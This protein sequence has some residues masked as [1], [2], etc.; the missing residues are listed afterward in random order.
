MVQIAILLHDLGPSA[1]V[2]NSEGALDQRVVVRSVA[3]FL[4]ER[5]AVELSQTVLSVSAVRV[6]FLDVEH[7]VGLHKMNEVV[8]ARLF[9]VMRVAALMKTFQ[10]VHERR[11]YRKQLLVL[12]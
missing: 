6:P 10:F 1:T 9:C 4:G 5:V 11:V 8:N 12:V 7:V 3:A 2:F